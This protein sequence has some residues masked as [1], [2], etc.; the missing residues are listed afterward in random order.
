MKQPVDRFGDDEQTSQCI[1]LHT[2]QNIGRGQDVDAGLLRKFRNGLRGDACR[3]VERLGRLLRP[4]SADMGR[5]AHGQDDLRSADVFMQLGHVSLLTSS[6][7]RNH[8]APLLIKT[9]CAAVSSDG[10]RDE[11]IRSKD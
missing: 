2:V 11:V 8:A 1:G 4:H 5:H 10:R 9:E 3:Y 7:F 6:D